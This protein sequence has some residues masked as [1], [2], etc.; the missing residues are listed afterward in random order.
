[1]KTRF[2]Q[3]LPP[4]RWRRLALYILCAIGVILIMGILRNCGPGSTLPEQKKG[5]S[6]GDTIDVAVVYGP[7]SYYLR[8]GKLSGINYEKLTRMRDSLGWKLRLWPV[9]S[10]QEALDALSEGRYDVVA[11]LPSDN[12][13]KKRYLT[14]DEVYLDRLV[15]IQGMPETGRKSV[16]SALDLA[17]DTI[18]VERGSAAARRIHN[19]AREIGDTIT[20]IEEDLGEEY[21]TMKV[22]T[23][24]MQFAVVNEQT[25]RKM[26]ET[27]YPE[28]D[29]DTPVAFTQF[30]VWV[31]RRD[32]SSLL[33]SINASLRQL[34]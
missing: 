32:N 6:G 25:A 14:T 5:F 4:L 24:E 2:R 7:G 23:G 18:H 15:L 21:L 31:V 16:K 19:L 1:M 13:V 17:G 3:P 28:L 22:A 30:Q 12:T 27:R 26:K 29:T 10:A 34:K 33:E 9:V 11:S 20:V 8:E